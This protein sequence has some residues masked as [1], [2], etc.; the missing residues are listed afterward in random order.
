[1]A[2]PDYC[3]HCQKVLDTPTSFS[4]L[5]L[6]RQL[7]KELLCDECFRLFKPINYSSACSGC[8]KPDHDPGTLCEDCEHWRTV[9]PGFETKNLSLFEYSTFAKAWM[10]RFKMMGDIRC[11]MVFNK[12]L[13]K[14][15]KTEFRDYILMPIPSSK[16]SLSQRGFNQIQVI[17]DSTKLTYKKLLTNHSYSMNQS[18][19]NRSERMKSSQP[20]ELKN[21]RNI[22]NKKLLII[23][24]VYTTGRTVFHAKE[25]LYQ[26]GAQKVDSLTVFR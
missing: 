8:S 15:I 5:F 18:K 21:R 7:K 17:L 16:K 13:E 22:V 25:L 9:Y 11:G 1:M 2:N 24:D 6:L 20:F 14:I 26:N 3:L 19:K 10:I 4:D 12:T 23:D